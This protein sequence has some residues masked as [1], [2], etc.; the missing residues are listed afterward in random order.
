MQVP[1]KGEVTQQPKATMSVDSE[2]ADVDEAEVITDEAVVQA[3]DAEHGVRLAWPVLV[4]TSAP[5]ADR[6]GNDLAPNPF[7]PGNLLLQQS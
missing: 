3:R 5:T 2:I 1:G 4:E 6:L 7:R